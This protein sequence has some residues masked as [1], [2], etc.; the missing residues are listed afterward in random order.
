MSIPFLVA[1]L[2]VRDEESEIGGC[3]DALE[4]V[5]DAVRVHDTGSRDRTAQ[6]AAERGATVTRGR[7]QDDFAAARNEAL[8]GWSAL[9]VMTVDA[10]QRYAGD[11]REL[12]RFLE[13]CSADVVEVEVDNA[14]DELPYTNTAAHLHR[15]GAARWEG[16]VHER[17]TGTTVAAPRSAIVLRHHGYAD[18]E[19]RAA[20]ARRN[21]ELARLTLAEAGDDRELIARTLLDLGR[22][23]VGAGRQQEA[24]DTFETL[25]ELFPGTPEWL[26]GTDFLA[27]L[28][29]AAGLDDVCL[30]LTEQL[31][32]AGARPDY[33]DWLAAQALAQ[34]GELATAARLLDGVAEVVD[35]SGRRQDPRALAELRKL[36]AS[37]R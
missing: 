25:R 24:A 35:T 5:V 1:S 34:L 30:T 3:L 6:I 15:K 12:R 21:V 33:C 2:I 19:H 26:H 18:P 7:W 4:G 37:V 13:A 10:D 11:P 31:R 14:H 22:S 28:V 29:L 32:A 23:L 20:K 27:R 17:L 9:W 36:M 16:R 8:E